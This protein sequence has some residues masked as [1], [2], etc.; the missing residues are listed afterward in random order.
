MTGKGELDSDVY[1]SNV[2]AKQRQNVIA[3]QE[4]QERLEQEARDIGEA[5]QNASPSEKKEIENDYIERISE[6]VKEDVVSLHYLLRVEGLD[7]EIIFRAM[8]IIAKEQITEINSIVCEGLYGK[9]IDDAITIKGIELMAK[10]GEIYLLSCHIYGGDDLS[11]S[12]K[13]HIEQAIIEAIE[14]LVR[15]ENHPDRFDCERNIELVANSEDLS[16]RV[17]N[18]AREALQRLKNPLQ[19]DGAPFK[20]SK[21]LDMN[22]K[23]PAGVKKI[24][25]KTGKKL[26]K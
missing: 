4:K 2:L 1:D 22:G 24:E 5:C 3:E 10:Q 15:N 18:T 26:K 19:G 25:K 21:D 8:E 11:D 9:G 14:T 6:A 7:N 16:S 20:N 17:R 13:D 12:M 23:T